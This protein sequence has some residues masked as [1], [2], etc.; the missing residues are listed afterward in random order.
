MYFIKFIYLAVLNSSI[1][2]GIHTHIP[3]KIGINE[4]YMNGS[5]EMRNDRMLRKKRIWK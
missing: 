4:V 3:N 2:S 5:A 1:I